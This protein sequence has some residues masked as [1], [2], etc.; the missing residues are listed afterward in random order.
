[1]SNIYRNFAWENTETRLLCVQISPGRISCG[2]NADQITLQRVYLG[3][4]GLSFDRSTL[5]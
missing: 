2:R 3:S 5:P 1:M 4:N